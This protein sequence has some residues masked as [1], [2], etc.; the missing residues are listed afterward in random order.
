ML[1]AL[2]S[3][4]R[5]ATMNNNKQMMP[6]QEVFASSYKPYPPSEGILNFEFTPPQRYVAKC[7]IGDI[8]ASSNVAHSGDALHSLIIQICDE[9]CP[10]LNRKGGTEHG[11]P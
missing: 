3:I 5:G 1:I 2:I 4:R 8:F 9:Y 11:R 6:Y 10:Y 7:S